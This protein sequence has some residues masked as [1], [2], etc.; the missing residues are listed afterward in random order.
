MESLAY[1]DP[2]SLTESEEISLLLSREPK[3]LDIL[4]P[5]PLYESIKPVEIKGIN[6]E[7]FQLLLPESGRV[8]EW[9]NTLN[10]SKSLLEYSNSR[11]SE[12]ENLN[13]LGKD[14]FVKKVLYLKQLLQIKQDELVRKKKEIQ[15]INISRQEST[16]EIASSL[17]S[18]NN[19]YKKILLELVKVKKELRNLEKN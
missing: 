7:K 16:R 17:K 5:F 13:R 10:N 4:N 15:D 18:Y 2:L 14:A 6:L 3:S 12:L 11:I 9:E 1:L 19:K 8:K